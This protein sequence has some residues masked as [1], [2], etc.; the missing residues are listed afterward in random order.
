M[1]KS[2]GDYSLPL[3]QLLLG[4]AQLPRDKGGLTQGSPQLAVLTL[5]SRGRMGLQGPQARP[6]VRPGP[7]LTLALDCY[8]QIW[9]IFTLMTFKSQIK[10]ILQV[11]LNLP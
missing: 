6:Q 5:L 9:G 7:L 8:S 4:L 2:F 11:W 3:H 1:A 10:L